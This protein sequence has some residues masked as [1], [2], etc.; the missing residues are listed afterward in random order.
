V[1][2]AC[3]AGALVDVASV[4]RRERIAERL[5]RHFG[6]PLGWIEVVP[7]LVL[8]APIVVGLLPDWMMLIVLLLA[9]RPLWRLVDRIF[10]A[11]AGGP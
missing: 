8:G 6:D 11:W 5:D 1:G 4:A 9:V 10:D 7:G 2:D 3:T